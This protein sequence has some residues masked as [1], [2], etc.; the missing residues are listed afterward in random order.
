MSKLFFIFFFIILSY[1]SIKD[2]FVQ[3]NPLPFVK[4][5]GEV[6]FNIDKNIYDAVQNVLADGKL[7]SYN[8][9]SILGA[10]YVWYKI[11]RFL[12]NWV[13]VPVFFGEGSTSITS[14]GTTFLAYYGIMLF[15]SVLAF[16]AFKIHPT[17]YVPGSGLYA[18]F[19]SLFFKS[20]IIYNLGTKILGYKDAI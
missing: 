2:S 1:V 18:L 10:I 5:V 9:L 6:F 16:Y 3:G 17:F 12:E 7:S 14:Y 20:D 11:I 19:Y 13:I 8:V 15:Y 4:A